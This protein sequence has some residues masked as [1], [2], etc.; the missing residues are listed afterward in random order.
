[1]T[2]GEDDPSQLKPKRYGGRL[3][4]EQKRA[5]YVSLPSDDMDDV[6]KGMGEQGG[7]DLPGS[8]QPGQSPPVRPSQQVKF[9]DNLAFRSYSGGAQA[10][11]ESG[12]A[13]L[14]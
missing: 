4:G 8:P 14:W 11:A 1:V 7:S 3:F 12:E 9:S 5:G 6:K 10:A 2:P 13:G